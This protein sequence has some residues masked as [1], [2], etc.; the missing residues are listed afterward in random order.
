MEIVG[1]TIQL[2]KSPIDPNP[3]SS[4]AT[5]IINS[6]YAVELIRPKIHRPNI[7]KNS[8]N[9]NGE[10]LFLWE[11]LTNLIKALNL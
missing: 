5:L 7:P 9:N 10:V 1:V 6:S 4:G 8:N 3:P 2:K 11:Y